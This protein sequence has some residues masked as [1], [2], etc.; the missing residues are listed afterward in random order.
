MMMTPLLH[1][2]SILPLLV[3]TPWPIA[4]EYGC[5]LHRFC[6]SKVTL[7]LLMDIH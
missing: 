5:W 6:N 1:L 3:K 7:D 2:A 4:K